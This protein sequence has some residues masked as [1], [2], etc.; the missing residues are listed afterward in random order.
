MP[1]LSPLKTKLFIKFLLMVGC[2]ERLNFNGS[3]NFYEREDLKRPITVIRSN[4]EQSAFIIRQALK[5]LG[6][7]ELEYLK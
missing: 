6:I 4:P 5:A 2:V 1:N 3:H 7:T